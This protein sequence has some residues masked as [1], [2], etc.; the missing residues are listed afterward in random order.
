MTSNSNKTYLILIRVT[1]LL[2]LIIGC[3]ESEL[4][5]QPETTSS[6]D[7]FK[8]PAYCW[9]NPLSRNSDIAHFS[10]ELNIPVKQMT[11]SIYDFAGG[12]V[13]EEQFYNLHAGS[14][15]DAPVTWNLKSQAGA[16]IARGVYIFCLEAEDQTRNR[17]DV[18][19]KI[20]VL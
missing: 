17:T 1:L 8:G 14:Y 13:Y 20:L 11:L 5:T 18:V 2:A 6:P 3:G 19:G 15:K 10:F 7:I 16:E 12:Q 9:P 4:I